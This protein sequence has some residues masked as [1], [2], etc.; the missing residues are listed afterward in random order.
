VS[1]FTKSG[2]VAF[3]QSP[4]PQVVAAAKLPTGHVKLLDIGRRPKYIRVVLHPEYV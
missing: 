1:E 2:Q 3:K 4:A